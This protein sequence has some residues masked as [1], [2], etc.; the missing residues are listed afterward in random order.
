MHH[1]SMKLSYLCDQNPS[2]TRDRIDNR[3]REK[4]H[5]QKLSKLDVEPRSRLDLKINTMTLGTKNLLPNK[6]N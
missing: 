3:S 1:L 5:E 4:I 6:K 2:H